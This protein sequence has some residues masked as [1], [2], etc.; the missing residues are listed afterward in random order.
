DVICDYPEEIPMQRRNLIVI[1]VIAIACA[2]LPSNA[3]DIKKVMNSALHS[4]E[5]QAL[6]QV[7]K[8]AAQGQTE[9]AG[10]AGTASTAATTATT[11]KTTAAS[12]TTA[13]HPQTTKQKIEARATH[14]AEKYGS[15]YANKYIKKGEGKLTNFLK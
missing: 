13:A 10:A 2:A 3:N 14:E 12:T 7:G 8:V 11:A 1:S 15:K 5:K 6:K 4:G 9:A